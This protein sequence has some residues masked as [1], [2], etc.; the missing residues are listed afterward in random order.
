MD[1]DVSPNEI[2]QIKGHKNVNSLNYLTSSDKKQ[3]Q[4]SVVLSN[5]ASTSQTLS[6]VSIEEKTETAYFNI[7]ADTLV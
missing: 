4:I 7:R 2:V 1:N 6:T 5:A 3:Q